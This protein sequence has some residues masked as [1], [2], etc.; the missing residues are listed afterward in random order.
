[1]LQHGSAGSLEDWRECGYVEALKHANRLILIDARGHGESDKPH[2]V[3][4]YEIALRA[5]DIIAVLDEL[6]VRKTGYMGYSLGGWIGFGLAKHAPER[7][8]ALVLGGAHPYAENMQAFRDLFPQDPEAFVAMM[9]PIWGE[10]F[11]SA[12]QQRLMHNDLAALA[13][14]THDRSSMAEVMPEMQMP[15]LLYCGSTDPR[16][17]QVRNCM[18]A[19][20]NASFVVLPDTSHVMGFARSGMILPFVQAFLANAR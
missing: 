1:M 16:L 14:S 11:S 13:A 10:Y 5:S 19:M 17:T 2:D 6:G 3:T 4:A 12:L 9:R 15:C 20:P 8:R 18:T 7:L